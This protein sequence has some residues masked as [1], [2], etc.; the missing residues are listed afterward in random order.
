LGT[1]QQ[2]KPTTAW[3]ATGAMPSRLSRADRWV[4]ADGSP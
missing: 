3:A 2:S 1:F 4:I